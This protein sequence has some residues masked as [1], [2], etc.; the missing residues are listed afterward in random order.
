[1]EE[2]LERKF[3]LEDDYVESARAKVKVLERYEMGGD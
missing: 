3:E 1:M 2:Y